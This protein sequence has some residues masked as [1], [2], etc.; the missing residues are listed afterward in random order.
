MTTLFVSRG[1]RRQRPPLALA[2][3]LALVLPVTAAVANSPRS[4]SVTAIW[5][6]QRVNFEY[7]GDSTVYS[8]RSLHDKLIMIL[9]TV[10]AREDV[11]LHNFMCDEK[12]RSARFQVAM[13]SPVIASEANVRDVT[14][15][16]T[17]EE[18][19]ARVSGEKLASATDLERFPAVWK[20][21]SFARDRGMRLERGDCEL[22]QQLRRQI[23]PHMSVR[24][25]K[26]NV[27]CSSSLGHIGPPRLTVSA[28]VRAPK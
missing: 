15:Y 25:V 16:D 26:D 5:K 8:C 13:K 19:I 23:L 10:G 9:R 28:L 2:C 7:R 22:V 3:M 27:R 24:V 18:L 17:Q 12:L 11:R 21:V 1:S 20:T 4:E 14:Q 6:A